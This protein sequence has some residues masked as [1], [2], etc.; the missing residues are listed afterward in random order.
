MSVTKF[1]PLGSRWPF[2]NFSAGSS[3]VRMPANGRPAPQQEQLP[4]CAAESV[5]EASSIEAGRTDVHEAGMKHLIGDVLLV[6][7]WGA[8]IPA[9]MW[10]GDAAGF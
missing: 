1:M 9:M 5:I 7:V 6:V 4:N 8:M 3:S 10:L 2:G